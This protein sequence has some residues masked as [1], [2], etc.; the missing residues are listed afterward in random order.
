METGVN[1]REGQ[2]SLR[3]KDFTPNKV[4]PTWEGP[5]HVPKTERLY[6]H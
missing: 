3:T 5:I 2:G 4:R 1:R 6:A